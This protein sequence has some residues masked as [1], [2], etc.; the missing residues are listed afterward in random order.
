MVA[1]T[2]Y[3]ALIGAAK[4]LV[5]THMLAACDMPLASAV[6]AYISANSAHLAAARVALAAVCRVPLRY[7]TSFFG[8]HCEALFPLRDLAQSFALEFQQAGGMG[9]IQRIRD[10]RSRR[11]TRIKSS[12]S[13]NL[14]SDLTI[15][16][17]KERMRGQEDSILFSQI[18]DEGGEGIVPENQGERSLHTRTLALRRGC[19]STIRR[20]LVAVHTERRDGRTALPRPDSGEP[21]SVPP[22]E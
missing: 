3:D 13:D 16:I 4:S 2:P 12:S 9:I 11:T 7:D 6:R 15:S 14:Q 21:L 17:S 10:R 19:R 18:G 5:D 22:L 20:S 8:E 1:A